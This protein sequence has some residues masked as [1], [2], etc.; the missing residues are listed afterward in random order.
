MLGNS[1]CGEN[2][3]TYTTARFIYTQA[4]IGLSPFFPRSR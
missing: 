1:V 3:Y 4:A 2:I